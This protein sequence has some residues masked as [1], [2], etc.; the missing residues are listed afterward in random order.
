MSAE[1]IVLHLTRARRE[2]ATSLWLGGGEPTLRKDSFAVVR[3]ARELGYTRVKLQTNGMLLAYPEVAE[4]YVRAGVTEVAFAIKGASAES[5]DRMTRTPGCYDLMLRG[6]AEV[7]R[8]ALPMEGD[9]LIY[10][11]TVDEL[12]Q[13]VE[14][15]ARLGLGHF[16]VWLF[17]A[18]DQ[19]DRDL[20][21]QVPRMREVMARI[22]ETLDEHPSVSLTSLHTPLCVIPAGYERAR[23]HAHDLDLVV[24]NPGGIRFWLE[25]SSIEGGRYLASC[26][27]C[28]AR[29]R[30]GGLRQDYLDVHGADEFRPL[31]AGDP[32]S[33]SEVT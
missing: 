30:C 15:H 14:K 7:A 21:S 31:R 26:E 33:S 19:G 32:R 9:L 13:M 20:A 6:M 4:R 22:T 23:F 18:A 5:H 8:H 16:N 25:E 1:E 10:A 29:P 17:S 11:S 12:P 2:G 27:A 24:A 3:K 28:T